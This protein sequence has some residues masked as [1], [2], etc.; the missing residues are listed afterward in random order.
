MHHLLRTDFPQWWASHWL[1]LCHLQDEGI[2]ISET[3]VWVQP[4]EHCGDQNIVCLHYLHGLPIAGTMFEALFMPSLKST[5]TYSA[6]W[7]DFMLEKPMVIVHEF[8]HLAPGVL[9]FRLQDR[10]LLSQCN[11]GHFNTIRP[12]SGKKLG[13]LSYWKSLRSC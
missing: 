4:W 11:E 3:V 10:H 5:W 7:R 2:L 6:S 8:S 1:V 12:R 9:K 13:V